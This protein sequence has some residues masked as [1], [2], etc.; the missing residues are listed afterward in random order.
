MSLSLLSNIN[1][2]PSKTD[3]APVRGDGY[4]PGLRLRANAETSHSVRIG[5]GGGWLCV[6]GGGGKFSDGEILKTTTC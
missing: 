2:R 3:Y 1:S 6:V 4:E 5:P